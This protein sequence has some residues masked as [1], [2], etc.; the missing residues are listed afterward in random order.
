[1]TET[2]Y[3]QIEN[4]DHN[5]EVRSWYY[6]DLGNRVDKKTGKFVVLVTEPVADDPQ[7]LNEDYNDNTEFS[8]C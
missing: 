5:P 6:D 3:K 8:G 2:L 7:I 4:M 1:M